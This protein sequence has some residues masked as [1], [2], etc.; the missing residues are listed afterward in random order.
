MFR[1]LTPSSR[2]SGFTLLELLVVMALIGLLSG[3]VAPRL[4]QWVDGAQHRAALDTIQ[5]TLQNLPSQTFFAGQGRTIV[6]AQD[7][8]L[9]LPEGWRLELANPLYYEAN[10]MTSGG[11][12]TL[13]SGKQLLATWQ[14][15]APS[16][17]LVVAEE[18]G[19]Q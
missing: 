2:Q 13:W 4:W 5:S 9:S 10:G 12:V 17:R 3:I 18:G 16:G 11:R 1:F 14:I 19:P 6:S 7:A 15:L 8:G